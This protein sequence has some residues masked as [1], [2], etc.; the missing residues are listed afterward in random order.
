MKPLLEAAMP[1]LFAVS[2]NG[3]DHAA[4]I[5]AG[6]G[7]MI[8]PLDSG[9]FDIQAFL[10]TLKDLGYTGPVG[11]QCYGLGGDAREHLSR[12]IAAWRKLGE[13]LAP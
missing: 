11:L 3:A 1:Y 5:R 7:K 2:I 6:K 12:S 13:R 4:D 8:L 9:T 10:K